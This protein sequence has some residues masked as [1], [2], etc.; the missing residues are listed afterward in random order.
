[1]SKNSSIPAS[2]CQ[3]M[4]DVRAG[5]D[6]LDQQLVELIVQRFTYMQAAARI[7]QS[8]DIVRDEARKAEVLQN[9]RKLAEEAGLP[10]GLTDHLWEKLI[11]SSI[12]YEFEE[13]DKRSA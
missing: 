11:E 8:R 4:T 2:E 7:K 1:M 6:A 10:E 13:W 9:V 3:T 12:A 5:V